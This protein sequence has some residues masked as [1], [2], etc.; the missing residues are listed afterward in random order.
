MPTRLLIVILLIIVNPSCKNK[1]GTAADYNQLN[2]FSDLIEPNVWQ[3]IGPF[4]APIPLAEKNEWSAFGS[5]RFESINLHPDN[6]NEIL[7]GHA[8][9]GLFKTTDGG[10]TWH[11]KLDF[12]F[13]TGIFSI[14]RFN[15]NDKH[16]LASCAT[17]LGMEKQFGYGLIESFD[18]G[19]TWQR[20]SLQYNP[21]EYNYNQQRSIEII[22]K[23]NEQ[24]LLSISDHEIFITYDGAKTWNSIYKT[25]ENLKSIKVNPENEKQIFVTGNV[26]IVSYDGGETWTDETAVVAR[27][28]GATPGKNARYEIGFSLKNNK[29]LWIAVSHNS[30]YLLQANILSLREIVLVSHSEFIANIYHMCMAT[31]YKDFDGNEQLLVGTTRVF[32][33]INGGASFSQI[34]TPEYLLPNNTHDDVNAIQITANKHIY[35]ATDGGI[36]KSADGGLTW[37]SLTNKALNLNASLLF[38]F[39]KAINNVI[40]AGTQDKGIIVFKKRKWNTCDLYGDGGRVTAM[41]DSLSF[42][43]GYAKMCYVTKNDGRNLVYNH[44]GGDINFFDFRM[45]Y[46]KGENTLYI[47]NQHLYKQIEGKNF[48]I[49][50]SALSTERPIGAFWVNPDNTAEIWLSKMDATWGGP[51]VKKLYYTNDGGLVWIDKSEALPILKWRSITDIDVNQNGEIAITLNGF[52]N[53]KAN[54]VNKVFLSKDGGNSFENMSEGLSNHPVFS[55]EPI[56]NDWICGNANGVFIKEPNQKW[57]PFGKG[58]PSVMVSEIKYYEAQRMLFV[59][60]FGRGMWRLWLN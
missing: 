5:G 17:D 39:D 46:H 19:E 47:A 48:E 49:L 27:S 44:A 45:A 29:K 18:N 2:A 9:A 35:I 43:C 21:S 42:A 24:K 40:M 23:R 36:D 37:F 1:K 52:D 12:E 20:N 4:G 54:E 31:G 16:L 34:T 30:S 50:S 28:Y 8:S 59:S 26:L 13:A 7:I 11:Q 60:T 53:S 22:D 55:I 33:S 10:I 41:G 15:K 14:L 51:L 56:G 57:M 3:A 58:F 38:G 32:K 25:S 6:E